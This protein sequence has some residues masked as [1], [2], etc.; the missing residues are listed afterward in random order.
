M[1]EQVELSQAN[2][3]QAQDM[4]RRLEQQLKELQAAKDD[5][6]NRQKELQAMLQRLE[7]AKNMES[8]E[9]NKLE[10]E[11]KAKQVEVQRIQEEVEAKDNETRRLQEEVEEARRQQVIFIFFSFFLILWLTNQ[12]NNCFS[13]EK[14]ALCVLGKISVPWRISTTLLGFR[15]AIVTKKK[16]NIEFLT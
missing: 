14:V 1:E 7:D 8:A 9:R 2:L 3:S 12:E 13:Q 11:I 5:L 15:Q 6:E 10:E 4:I 16:K